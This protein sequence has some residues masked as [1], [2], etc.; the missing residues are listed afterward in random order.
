[1]NSEDREFLVHLLESTPDDLSFLF[2]ASARYMDNSV[3]EA[4]GPAWL[5]VQQRNEI[6]QLIEAVRRE[7]YDEGLDKAG[8]SGPELAF[9]RAGWDNA[10]Q[11]ALNTPTLRPLK[12]WLKWIDVILGSLLSVIGVGEGLKELKEGVEAELEASEED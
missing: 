10:R 11:T 2:E 3:V 7:A 4:L 9:K 6:A 8:L 12:R 1:M 5:A